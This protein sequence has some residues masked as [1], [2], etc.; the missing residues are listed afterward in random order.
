MTRKLISFRLEKDKNL[1]LKIRA[2][3]LDKTKSQMIEEMCMVYID[4]NGY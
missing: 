1:I 2:R 4:K 3:F